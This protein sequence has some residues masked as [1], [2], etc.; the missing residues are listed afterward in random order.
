MDGK[1]LLGLTL[2]VALTS[3]APGT[4]LGDL[5]APLYIPP[6]GNTPVDRAD[7]ADPTGENPS[8]QPVKETGN[9]L[10]SVM[11]PP[12]SKSA[13]TGDPTGV[14]PSGTDPTG[15]D[16]TDAASTTTTPPYDPAGTD[17]L[18]KGGTPPGMLDPA[19]GVGAVPIDTSGT[20][21]TADDTVL[22]T[23][24]Q[25]GG[26]ANSA[27]ADGS[28]GVPRTTVPTG[29]D[30]T[31]VTAPTQSGS[32][33]DP[34]GTPPATTA[35]DPAASRPLV[36]GPTGLDAA[37]RAAA[38]ASA[39]LLSSGLTGQALQGH[40][41]S[42]QEA[43]GASMDRNQ[44]ISIASAYWKLSI[45]VGRYNWALSEKTQL[46]AVPV[47]NPQPA[48]SSALA[49]AEAR[50]AE[51]HVEVIAAQYQLVEAMGQQGH[52]GQTAQTRPWPVDMPLV[53]PYRTYFD[54]LLAG[55]MVPIRMRAIDASLPIQREA[56]D[57]RSAAVQAAA[58]NV[59]NTEDNYGAGSG[60]LEAMLTA[61]TNLAQQR[62]AFLSSV[63]KYNLDIVEYAMTVAGPDASS[64]VLVTMLTRTK[65]VTKTSATSSAAG[66]VAGGAAGQPTLAD[67]RRDTQVMP[68]GK[69]EPDWK[70]VAPVEASLPAGS[71]LPAGEASGLPSVLR[72]GSGYLPVSP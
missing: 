32:A 10:R 24:F 52:I 46:A 25:P 26:G 12:R 18:G 64:A 71:G 51:M 30:P 35:T 15:T 56:I 34:L 7:N 3:F 31:R 17:T 49:A 61:Y 19:L 40:P 29:A 57:L 22:Q 43:L 65:P 11:V 4:E 50:V 44:R 45:A 37:I 23:Q 16:P 14:D 1:F 13:A 69:F 39:A 62:Q 66:H 59:K 48:L 67:P 53:G 68:A 28:A 33:G 58:S 8:A 55:R 21:S 42:L 47:T 38:N 6:V 54:T 36:T 72:P 5:P 60:S 63:Q 70:G 41:L 27:P 9:P 2:S 20:G